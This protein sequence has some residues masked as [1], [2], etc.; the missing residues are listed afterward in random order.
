M[1]KF[2]SIL[3]IVCFLS[4]C[5]GNEEKTYLIQYV[6]TLISEYPN[7]ASNEIAKRSVKDSIRNHIENQI[8]K[9]ASD[10]IGLEL[11]FEKI[12]D[13]QNG[14]CAIFIARPPMAFIDNPGN[15]SKYISADVSLIV[16]SPI[17]DAMAA[18]L[19]NHQT[20]AITGILDEW[21]A[22]NL[23]YFDLLSTSSKSLDFGTYIL[24]DAHITE[25]SE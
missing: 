19:G 11:K 13:G 6:E 1:R 16:F 2:L 21:D 18:K 7:F 4:S 17:D 10:L 8:G 15:K 3:A 22:D 24:K 23:I 25:Y 20:Y 9:P 12:L 14:K 5:G